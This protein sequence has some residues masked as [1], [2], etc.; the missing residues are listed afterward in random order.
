MSSNPPVS[1]N[2][3]RARL[4]P[5]RGRDPHESGRSASTLELLF[6]LTFVVAVATSASQLAHAL[7]VGHVAMGL[8]AFAFTSFGI[9]WAWIN[10]SW[11]ASAYDT[12]DWLYRL[13]TMLQ[14][15]GVVVFT[16]GIKDT[17]DALTEEHHFDNTII[18]VGYVIMRVAMLAQ[19]LRA[20]RSDAAH[21]S[22]I[23]T[24]AT[25]LVVAQLLWVGTIFLRDTHWPLS[26]CFAITSVIT[27][28]ELAG[29][30]IAERGAGTPW[31]AHHIVERH[32]LL[33][34]ITIGEVVT[35]TVLTLE[36]IKNADGRSID[37]SNAVLVA[38]A[39]VALAFGLWWVYFITP[40]A[41]VLH[42]FRSR[43]FG[44]G[45][46]HFLIWPSI[47]AIGGGLHVMALTFEETKEG[48]HGVDHVVAASSLA[49]P[50][51][52][53]MVGL[54]LAHYFTTR[55]WARLHTAILAASLVIL[56]AAVWLAAHHAP[57]AVVLVLVTL[58]PWLV[59]AAFELYRGADHEAQ[60]L[61]GL[62][63]HDAAASTT[64]TQAPSA[65]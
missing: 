14:M 1:A 45:Y 54:F 23:R 50:V 16:L 63:E 57:L 2:D 61:Q 32:G 12:D 44:F 27:L 59:V 35:G 36:E 46:S 18:V 29:P 30:V 62:R 5:M 13:L 34:I 33:T 40:F 64:S 15:A 9:L 8:A 7:S 17:F 21:R 53:F 48:S 22:S 19:W 28:I 25:T 65:S 39:G 3:L 52:L 24:Y 11:F 26:V 58:V 31:H 6:D 41:D 55:L 47:A 10:Y 42:R 49:V 4:K 43:S 37:W 56:A 38:V 60:V 20:A 51:G